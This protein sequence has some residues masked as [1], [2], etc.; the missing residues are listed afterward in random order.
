MK[1][2]WKRKFIWDVSM[3]VLVIV[4]PMLLYCH[5]WF[6]EA[7]DS[8]WFF[9]FEYYHGYV[10][11]LSF[12]WQFLSKTIA[13]LLLSLWYLNCTFYWSRYILISV[14]FWIDE[15]L[16]NTLIRSVH[17]NYDT[18]ILEIEIVLAVI[19]ILIIT[20][21]FF[22]DKIWKCLLLFPSGRKFLFNNRLFYDNAK[23]KIKAI[24]ETSNLRDINGKIRE[25]TLMKLYLSNSNYFDFA[26]Q[27]NKNKFK[28]TNLFML[29][30]FVFYPFVVRL[31]LFFPEDI[32]SYSFGFFSINSNGFKDLHSHLYYLGL[33]LGVLFP[34]LVWYAT[35]RNWWRHALFVPFILTVYQ[36]WEIYNNNGAVD[37]YEMVK[38]FPVLVVCICFMIIISRVVRYNYKMHDLIEKIKEDIDFLITKNHNTTSNMT[39]YDEILNNYE[40]KNSTKRLQELIELKKSLLNE[41]S[42][43]EDGN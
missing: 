40:S 7:N 21:Y 11:N 30:L 15:I 29:L 37:E 8:F 6:S 43:I 5:L 23:L 27:L 10:D 36:I 3:A 13:L 28:I 19:S 20:K 18:L 24:K 4:L 9:G 22:I 39:E 32:R 38:S 17:I 25:L 42:E 2:F 33:K 34:I 1:S 31:W 26:I 35:D 12:A 16:R 41:I 14:V